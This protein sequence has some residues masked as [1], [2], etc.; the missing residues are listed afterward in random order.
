MTAT[1]GAKNGSNHVRGY[2]GSY[3]IEVVGDGT[4]VGTEFG[5]LFLAPF[6]DRFSKLDEGKESSLWN[7]EER[8]IVVA[9]YISV[10]AEH[11]GCGIVQ[12]PD[13]SE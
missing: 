2:F 12:I 8:F 9:E 3:V 7:L 4:A 11:G 5:C 10:V 13:L 6:H 1:G